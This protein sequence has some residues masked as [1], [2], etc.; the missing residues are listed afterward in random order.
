MKWQWLLI[1][2]VFEAGMLLAQPTIRSASTKD[3]KDAGMRFAMHHT[4]GMG[5]S[6]AYQGY[7]GSFVYQ[8]RFGSV[9][10]LGAMLEGQ[11]L[12]LS[13]ES[14]VRDSRLILIAPAVALRCNFNPIRYKTFVSPYFTLNPG[15]MVIAHNHVESKTA[16]AF[17]KTERLRS[18]SSL[19]WLVNSGL[20]L[21]FTPGRTVNVFVQANLNFTT[22]RHIDPKNTPEIFEGELPT[23]FIYYSLIAGI[24]INLN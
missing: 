10:S 9:F 5:S 24:G 14:L 16:N 3:R 20:G 15:F 21:E 8:W 4:S 6:A 23:G 17:G 1:C 22:L 19:T 18:Y 11:S 7:G 13:D 12:K 2:F